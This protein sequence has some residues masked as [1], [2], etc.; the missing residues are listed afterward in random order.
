MS[1][2]LMDRQAFLDEMA[3]EAEAQYQESM[4]QTCDQCLSC[5]LFA[6]D[7]NEYGWAVQCRM[8]DIPTACGGPYRRYTP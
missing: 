2:E 4:A 3:T 1:N 7:Q 5:D 8:N 6:L